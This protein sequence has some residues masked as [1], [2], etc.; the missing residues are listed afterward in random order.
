MV[1]L[2]NDYRAWDKREE[3]YIYHV[4]QCLTL[5]DNSWQCR[6]C[7][8]DYLKNDDYIVEQSIG[9]LDIQSKNIYEGDIVEGI[10]LN[11]FKFK[12]QIIRKDNF[13]AVKIKNGTI[14]SQLA[15]YN[16]KVLGNIHQ[17]KELKIKMRN[18][19]LKPKKLKSSS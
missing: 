2:I 18:Q 19:R 17:I 8:F 14:L 11:S 5:P 13:F 3:R 4:Q 12:G 9:L 15:T 1:A 10:A 16:L 6:M 7:F